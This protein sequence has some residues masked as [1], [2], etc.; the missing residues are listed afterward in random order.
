M[1]FETVHGLE[2]VPL[3][4]RGSALGLHAHAAHNGAAD[5]V[6]SGEEQKA[7]T[8]THA[9]RSQKTKQMVA[10]VTCQVGKDVDESDA[11]GCR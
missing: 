5:Q 8:V 10:K 2:S 4:D 9:A 3:S 1:I 6:A 11:R 7:G